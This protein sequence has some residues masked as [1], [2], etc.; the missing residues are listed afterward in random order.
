M[1]E[2]HATQL[3]APS[4]DQHPKILNML[5]M[6]A[7]AGLLMRRATTTQGLCQEGMQG[8]MGQSQDTEK[9]T[10]FQSHRRIIVR[11]DRAWIKPLI[12][13]PD[14]CLT[15]FFFSIEWPVRIY[16][17]EQKASIVASKNHS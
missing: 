2:G 17:I 7:M 9:I 12:S 5:T 15:L 4:K 11:V 3:P 13:V 1:K 6:R 10:Q 8:A 14:K 16:E